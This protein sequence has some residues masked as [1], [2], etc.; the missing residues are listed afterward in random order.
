MNNADKQVTLQNPAQTSKGRQEKEKRK[1]QER[2]PCTRTQNL[3]H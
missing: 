1:K 3:M 2:N